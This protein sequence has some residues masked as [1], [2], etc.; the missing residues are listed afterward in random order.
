MSAERLMAELALTDPEDP[1][2]AAAVM[3]LAERIMAL[4]TESGAE[5]LVV[6]GALARCT[7]GFWARLTV[8]AG[9]PPATAGGAVM[10]QAMDAA[11]VARSLARQAYARRRPTPSRFGAGGGAAPRQSG[12]AGAGGP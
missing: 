9:E 10:R 2:V 5:R 7:A 8:D 1:A 3:E 11:T 12:A 4:T 6:G